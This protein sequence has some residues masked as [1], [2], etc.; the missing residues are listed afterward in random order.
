MEEGVS[1]IPVKYTDDLKVRAVELVTHAQAD[2]DTAGGVIT[3]V[4][5]ELGLSRATSRVLVGQHTNSERA[6]PAGSVDL[7]SENRRLRAELA[8]AKR[9]NEILTLIQ[10][11]SSCSSLRVVRKCPF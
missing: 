7:Q 4:A 9:A 5:N 10:D 2:P 6:T 1:L 11:V 3:S 8:E